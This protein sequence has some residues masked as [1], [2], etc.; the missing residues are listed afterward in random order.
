M[1]T[2]NYTLFLSFKGSLSITETIWGSPSRDTVRVVGVE[3][4]GS[5]K[6]SKSGAV[7]EPATENPN[8]NRKA[9][10]MEIV[11][12]QSGTKDT[13]KVTPKYWLFSVRPL[14]NHNGAKGTQNK[15]HFHINLW[16]LFKKSKGGNNG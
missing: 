13:L 12:K 6:P 1:D 15:P 4:K 7:P 11:R 5:H 14:D 10:N 8:R 2:W 3:S 9:D 16:K